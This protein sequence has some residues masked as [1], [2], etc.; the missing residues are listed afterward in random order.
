M[1]ASVSAGKAAG[2]FATAGAPDRRRG[3]NGLIADPFLQLETKTVLL[4]LEDREI[5]FLHQIN[6]GFDV[7]EFHGVALLPGE[8]VR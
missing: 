1:S 8:S 7:F 2:P 6:D 3:D 5:V 4:H